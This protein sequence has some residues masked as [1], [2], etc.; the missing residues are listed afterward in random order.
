M[1]PDVKTSKQGKESI[2][3][4]A[5]SEIT[6]P[7]VHPAVVIFSSKPR[8]QAPYGLTKLGADMF[9]RFGAGTVDSKVIIGG[10]ESLISGAAIADGMHWNLLGSVRTPQPK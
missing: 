7:P 9:A 4:P 3:F 10:Y 2:A 6:H 1:V 5:A 8:N